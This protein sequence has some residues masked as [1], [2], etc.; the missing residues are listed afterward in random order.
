VHEKSLRQLGERHKN[1]QF[2]LKA[3]GE[4][5]GELYFNA[6]DPFG[7]QASYQPYPAHNL[8]VPVT[9]VDHEIKSQQ[10]SGP[11]LIKLDTHGFEVPILKGAD[12]TLKQTEVV[13]MECY[14]FKIA[15]EGL[16]F[17]EMCQHLT[18]HGFRCVD[19]VDPLY[20]PYD[21]SFWQMDLVFV[22]EN[23]AEFAYNNYA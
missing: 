4:S 2:V 20:R 18:G 23:R 13:V 3:A 21:N 8:R 5:S 6:E 19:L 17:Y 14:N 1:F 22:R 12:T 15:P 11:Y 9:T 10:Y 7:V 16:L